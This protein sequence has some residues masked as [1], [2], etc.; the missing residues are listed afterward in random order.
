MQCERWSQLK[1]YMETS[2]ELVVCGCCGKLVPADNIEL[3]FSRP[4]D[5][6]QLSELEIA[7][8]CWLNDDICVLDSN[9]FFVRCIIPLPIAGTADNYA[10]GA[11]SEITQPD[12]KL[13][14]NSWD[15]ETQSNLS[16]FVGTL[17]NKVPLTQGSE[18][19]S[20]KV[21]LTGP[22]TRPEIEISD[23]ACSLYFGQK[24]GISLHKASEYSDWVRR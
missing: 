1:E 17:A 10:I 24:N 22:A 6:A 20:V 21:V 5:I 14:M 3:S 13:I 23:T 19:C 11:W 9:R 18:N 2:E 12:F 7:E 8:R 16:A 4:D 15:D